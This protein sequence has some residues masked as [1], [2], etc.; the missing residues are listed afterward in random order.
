MLSEHS[1]VASPEQTI[2]E[3]DEGDT[4]SL[5]ILT[6]QPHGSLT[7]HRKSTDETNQYSSRTNFIDYNEIS[8]LERRVKIYDT[9]NN[10]LTLSIKNNNKSES[11]EPRTK[12]P[13]RKSESPIQKADSPVQKCKRRSDNDSVKRTC[14]KTWP[15]EKLLPG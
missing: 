14:S 3:D 8:T 10:T 9:V 6:K 5:Q 4:I 1:S 7:I 11:P 15:G 13:V 2:G 12:S